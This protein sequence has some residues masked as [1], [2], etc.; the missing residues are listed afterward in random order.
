MT[1]KR[2]LYA[3]E[4]SYADRAQ[5]AL[6]ALDEINAYVM[7]R[8]AELAREVIRLQDALALMEAERDA[9]REKA[10]R[11]EAWKKS[12]TSWTADSGEPQREKARGK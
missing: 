8:M 4:P 10:R 5:T 1:E 6:A 2:E 11:L 12:L 9:W 7:N 3:V